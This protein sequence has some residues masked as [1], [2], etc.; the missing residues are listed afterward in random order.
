MSLDVDTTQT[1]NG[2]EPETV[3]DTISAPVSILTE[4][5]AKREE[6]RGDHTVDLEVPGYQGLLWVRYGTIPLKEAE[7]L[8]K[9]VMKEQKDMR[10]LLGAVDTL[11]AA[12]R[13]VYVKSGDE[14]VSIDTTQDVPVLFDQRLADLL[15][16]QS[17]G[18]ARGVV[19]GTFS[20]DYAIV[21]QS[22]VLSRWMQNTSLDVSEV[23]L[24]E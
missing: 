24:G 21:Q 5:R 10:T 16:F 17:S 2:D 8:G 3:L 12:C 4:L 20:N 7:L 9:E 1:L 22:I 14:L 6:L 19:R 11:I 23:N 18:G 15:D 13:G